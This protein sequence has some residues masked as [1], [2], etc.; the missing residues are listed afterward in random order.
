ML[1]L[2]GTW[3]PGGGSSPDLYTPRLL[4][5]AH[6]MTPLQFPSAPLV[7]RLPCSLYGATPTTPS[8]GRLWRRGEACPFLVR[9][10]L[11]PGPPL[12]A[13]RHREPAG[14]GA[15]HPAPGLQV[16]GAPTPWPHAAASHIQAPGGAGNIQATGGQEYEQ[17]CAVLQNFRQQNGSHRHLFQLGKAVQQA[18]EPG[19]GPN[20]RRLLEGEQ[21]RPVCCLRG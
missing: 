5:P 19:C 8:T 3:I 13:P 12:P 10:V 16:P 15:R 7:P 14:R 17:M 21:L 18:S 4:A 2:D 20:T 6:L 1:V 9:P 11:G